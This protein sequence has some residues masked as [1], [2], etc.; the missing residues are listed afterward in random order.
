MIPKRSQVYINKGTHFARCPLNILFVHVPFATYSDVQIQSSIYTPWTATCTNMSAFS[1]TGI[2]S[3]SNGQFV[4]FYQISRANFQRCNQ[5]LK[6]ISTILCRPFGHLTPIPP[7]PPPRSPANIRIP[8]IGTNLDFFVL[9]REV[10]I[11]KL[12]N[13]PFWGQTN[14]GSHICL[15]AQL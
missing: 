6:K 5:V 7:P 8:E 1:K 13:I 9:S 14:F 12:Y 4:C 2:T 3:L 11:R 10:N 15:L